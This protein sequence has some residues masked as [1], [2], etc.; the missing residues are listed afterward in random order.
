MDLERKKVLAL[1]C[2]IAC[3]DEAQN[4]LQ[5]PRRRCWWRRPAYQCCLQFHNLRDVFR[6]DPS[7]CEVI[8]PA[9][10]GLMHAGGDHAMQCNTIG[11]R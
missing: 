11:L 8:Y 1:I 6:M 2:D 3:V 7:D 10:H 4:L 5:K 9:V